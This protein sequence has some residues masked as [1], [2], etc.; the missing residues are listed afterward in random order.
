MNP[1]EVELPENVLNATNQVLNSLI[2]TKSKVQARALT[3]NEFHKFFM[4]A[5]DEEY[6]LD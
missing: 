3:E 1:D 2:P 6:L 5:T 4:E